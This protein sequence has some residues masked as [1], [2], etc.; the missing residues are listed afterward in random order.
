MVMLDSD[1]AE[2]YQV[3][4]KRINERVKRNI[5]RFPPDFMFELTKSEWESLRS[6]NATSRW[7]GRRSIPYAFSE[8]GILMLSSV[9]T[10][11]RAVQVNILIMR[12]YTKMRDIIMSNKDV[13]MKMTELELKITN[14]DQKMALLFRYLK[15]FELRK[16]TIV[17]EHL[18]D[19]ELF[20][21]CIFLDIP[22]QF[23]FSR[24]DIMKALC[25]FQSIRL[26]H[27]FVRRHAPQSL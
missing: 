7:G 2:M 12:T 21:N 15:E 4:T 25:P 9:L 13:L 20:F 3:E 23:R 27:L 6:Q 16:K 5:D 22:L 19:F 8:H 11:Q 17:K 18:S 10:S 26:S 14:H 24:T 1:L